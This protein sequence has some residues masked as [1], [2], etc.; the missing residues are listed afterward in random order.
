MKRAHLILVLLAFVVII[1][2]CAQLQEPKA[3]PEQEP[4]VFQ[5]PAA[6]LSE[7]KTITNLKNG[8]IKAVEFSTDFSDKSGI[9]KIEIKPKED[10]PSA[11]IRVTKLQNPP[12]KG[13]DSPEKVIKYIE[14]SVGS[15]KE[16]N[17]GGT[18][19]FKLT[20]AELGKNQLSNIK[21]ARLNPATNKWDALFTKPFSD[22]PDASLSKL[23][24]T[25][26]SGNPLTEAKVADTVNLRMTIKNIGKVPIKA[27][28]IS[29]PVYDILCLS[30]ANCQ[31][32]Q[33]YIKDDIYPKQALDIAPG[34]EQSDII[35]SGYKFYD[36]GSHC[37]S[38]SFHIL[39]DSGSPM[40]ELDHNNNALGGFPP[41]NKGNCIKVIDTGADEISQEPA[42]V[43][44]GEF[45]FEASTAG[46]SYFAIYGVATSNPT[47]TPSPSP[48]ASPSVSPSPSQKKSAV[49]TLISTSW[50]SEFKNILVKAF[51]KSADSDQAIAGASCTI[52]YSDNVQSLMEFSSPEHRHTRTFQTSP[53][54][55]IA[56]VACEHNDYL[57]KTATLNLATGAVTTPLPSP[58]LSPS[59][60]ASPSP[61][62]A[63]EL[64]APKM[65]LV[66]PKDNTSQGTKITFTCTAEGEGLKEIALYTDISGS[67]KKDEKK[68]V[69]DS[70]ATVQFRKENVPEGKYNWN[71]EAT[72]SA[73]SVFLADDDRTF[74]VKLATSPL[75]DVVCSQTDD[76]GSW[77]PTTCP[78]S[79]LQTRTCSKYEECGYSLT[80]TCT[81]A[82][83]GKEKQTAAPD[84]VASTDT[85]KAESELDLTLIAISAGLT[86]SV[87]VAIVLVTRRRKGAED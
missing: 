69:T 65:K 76:C 79:E 80:R 60:V 13:F 81:P 8:V 25:D 42:A 34:A 75:P 5:E 53:L 37:L 11:E 72:T 41:D 7:S 39:D 57:E 66:S 36:A 33:K 67:W 82:Q 44:E 18:I 6:G 62:T 64:T 49:L 27:K 48:S 35:L 58:S 21:A 1:S 29:S 55:I 24:Y 30:E 84:S 56:T 20:K 43:N 45:L 70:P 28:S 9:S 32:M 46:F 74:E 71:C 3:S 47:P 4:E 12:E 61:I 86:F 59:P 38:G 73:G 87:I 78:E 23:E 26:S 51:Y 40:K 17:D 15:L 19:F 83:L 63:Q 54:G 77:A 10:L 50:S 16:K 14:I 85:E 2:G 31:N 52:K 22:L 68:L